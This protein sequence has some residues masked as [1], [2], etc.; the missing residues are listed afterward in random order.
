MVM[1]TIANDVV[2]IRF[3][4]STVVAPATNKQGREV[5]L[6]TST[7][8]ESR[9]SN[10]AE[11]LTADYHAAVGLICTFKGD[12]DLMDQEQASLEIIKDKLANKCQEVVEFAL[13]T[14][15]SLSTYPK[16]LNSLNGISH[17]HRITHVDF[18]VTTFTKQYL[19]ILLGLIEMVFPEASVRVLYT[20]AGR[21][22]APGIRKR[23]SR[24]VRNIIAVPGYDSFMDGSN[25]KS[26]LVTF[27]GF[28]E[29]RVLTLIDALSPKVCIP[30]LQS[31]RNT[32]FGRLVPFESNKR[33]LR[34]VAARF[35]RN[36]EYVDGENPNE[37]VD[38][39]RHVYT[40][41][42]QGKNDVLL[43]APHG[44]KMQTVG[45]YLFCRM[46]AN[47]SQIG[48][49]YAL[50]VKYMK[51]QYSGNALEYIAAFSWEGASVDTNVGRM[52]SK[53][54]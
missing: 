26:T 10:I 46:A 29:E 39:L 12:Y 35:S 42:V 53:I 54:S 23:L 21:Y 34:L 13:K 24:H 8:F 16:L 40:N 18:D 20:P 30:V 11:I 19:L 3:R 51:K 1:S 4:T 50:P 47:P 17:E 49:V 52:L 37:T 32:H 31:R 45:I 41:Y 25:I 36:P 38:Y 28:E 2:N 9:C 22:G 6:I 48:I 33:L 14:Y 7:S 27:L 43:I 15:D 44:S 5:L